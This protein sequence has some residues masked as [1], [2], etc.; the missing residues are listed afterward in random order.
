MNYKIIF[1]DIDGVLNNNTLTGKIFART[2][3][4]VHPIPF[5]ENNLKNLK[6]IVFQTNSKIV[7]SSSWRSQQNEMKRLMPKLKEYH[8][9]HMFLH[10]QLLNQ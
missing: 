1:L 3:Q 7:I 10:N 4:T 9:H 5:D 2:H 6:S 8:F